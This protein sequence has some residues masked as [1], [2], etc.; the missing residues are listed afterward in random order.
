MCWRCVCVCVMCIRGPF[1]LTGNSS[2]LTHSSRSWQQSVDFFLLFFLFFSSSVLA[3]NRDA[4][5]GAGLDWGNDAKATL[6]LHWDWLQGRRACRGHPRT[7]AVPSVPPGHLSE[8]STGRTWT[9]SRTKC[10]ILLGLWD[11]LKCII[12]LSRHQGSSPTL[13]CKNV[14]AIQGLGIISF[15]QYCGSMQNM[16]HQASMVNRI[17]NPVSWF[18]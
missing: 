17:M 7:S 4:G 1:C 9:G 12:E 6:V 2:P 8:C 13:V 5:I 11:H 15:T 14:T 16:N 10:L 3:Q 18:E